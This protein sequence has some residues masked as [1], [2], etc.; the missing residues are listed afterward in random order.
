MTEAMVQG[1][2]VIS[3]TDGPVSQ[4]LQAIWQKLKDQ[5]IDTSVFLPLIDL[6]H[7]HE[8]ENQ[9]FIFNLE[10]LNVFLGVILY[11]IRLRGGEK[12]GLSQLNEQRDKFVVVISMIWCSRWV[13][14][15]DLRN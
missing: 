11:K 10:C 3:Y 1:V 14:G 7:S 4:A 15:L 2:S 12:A 13:Q 6:N 8:P 9:I 5:V